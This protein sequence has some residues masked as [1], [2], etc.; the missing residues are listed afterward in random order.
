M[1]GVLRLVATLTQ[2]ISLWE[3]AAG[4]IVRI[5]GIAAMACAVGGLSACSGRRPPRGNVEV[6]KR[7]S[8]QGNGGALQ[9]TSDF[10]LRGAM[11][12]GQNKPM[13]FVA[14]RR[15]RVPLDR[16]VLALDAWRL[17]T[18]YAHNGHF[19][20][21][22][23]GWDLIQRRPANR[24]RGPVVEI[25]GHVAEG[26]ASVVRSLSWQGAADQEGP[27]T[28]HLTRNTTPGVGE[29]FHL[30]GILESEA[31]AEDLLR[32]SSYPLVEVVPDVQAFP[33]EGAVD[34]RF[35]VE[36]G[37]SCTFGEV[38]VVTEGR[39][40]EDY[41]RAE[42]RWEEGDPYD[43]SALATTRRRLFGLG[44]FSV[45]NVEPMLDELEDNV[46]PVRIELAESRFQQ[47][48]LGGGVAFE[49]GKQDLHVS[50]DYQHV[51]IL[52]RLVRLNFDNEVGYTTLATFKEVADGTQGVVHVEGA[53][54]LDSTLRVRWPRF[55]SHS[56]RTE[57]EVSF[58]VGVEEAYRYA[59]P[60]VAPALHWQATKATSVILRYSLSYFDY[61][62]GQL[63]LDSNT[64]LG[65]DATD[66]YLLSMLGQ[67]LI[68]DRRDDLLSPRRGSYGLFGI[69]E[70]GSVLGGGY[71]FVRFTADQRLY[72]PIAQVGARVAHSAIGLR[73]GGGLILPYGGERAGVPFAERLKLGGSTDV[74]GWRSGHLGPYIC[75]VS[76]AS[77]CAS[78]PGRAPEGVELSEV[79]AI[80]GLLQAF[81]GVE[82]RA[83]PADPLGFVL[84]TDAGMTWND[85]SEVADIGLAPSVGVGGRYKSQIGPI[86]LDLGLR[87][88]RDP[89]FDLEQRFNL[90]FSLSEAF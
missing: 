24:R 7:I 80:G 15:R 67:Q 28:R 13:T 63:E 86:R 5:L 68:I 12:Q 29:R 78:S 81:G 17:E 10:A 76:V 73:A 30:D 52:N 34:V 23:F 70:A 59:T 54:T 45:V 21:Q 26:P 51:N 20:A 25:V 4:E 44:V 62:P 57:L 61:L 22:V 64:R 35:D 90:H 55:P 14:P 56:L 66:P 42:L 38:E 11:V 3:D 19:D 75:D 82:L 39:V 37:P 85:F 71:T 69:D 40:P 77:A 53:P 72:L 83:Y 47:L 6:V 50:A 31:M 32:D 74:R 79:V 18:W 49:S 48:R 8:F 9:G 46:V 84:F 60:E 87:L 16:D 27:L 1:R 36:R 88:D 58:E 33:K 41:V 65:L 43:A 89:M 2:G